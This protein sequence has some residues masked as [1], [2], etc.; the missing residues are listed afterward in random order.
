MTTPW[1]IVFS[2]VLLMPDGRVVSGT[3]Q[4]RTGFADE[5]SCLERAA[6]DFDH[7]RPRHV[8]RSGATVLAS[9]YRCADR[10]PGA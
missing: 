8:L 4:S 1:F 3:L 5:L 9:D 6:A 2:V 10:R 7:M